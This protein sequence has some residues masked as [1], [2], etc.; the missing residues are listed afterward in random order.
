M[1]HSGTRSP[2]T[3]SYLVGKN[4]ECVLHSDWYGSYL[5]VKSRLPQ[6]SYMCRLYSRRCYVIKKKGVFPR[7]IIWTNQNPEKKLGAKLQ[8]VKSTH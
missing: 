7:A 6:E 2:F 3:T 4:P 5:T 1:V 8:Y